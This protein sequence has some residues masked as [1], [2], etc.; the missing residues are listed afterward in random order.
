MSQTRILQQCCSGSDDP[1]NA[2]TAATT[3]S[4]HAAR[5]SK[6]VGHKTNLWICFSIAPYVLDR[7][8]LVPASVNNPLA[9]QG[10]SRLDSEH[11]IR[12]SGCH[13]DKDH[14]LNP[15]YD[16]ALRPEETVLMVYIYTQ[17][18]TEEMKR[19]IMLHDHHAFEIRSTVH[20]FRENHYAT[21]SRNKTRALARGS[22]I[23]ERPENMKHTVDPSAYTSQV[24]FHRPRNHTRHF[25]GMPA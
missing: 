8:A 20:T 21:R 11:I 9:G 3:L 19:E 14:S 17:A 24:F 25:V 6:S 23:L 13:S 18:T 15:T 12:V 7:N 4:T 1:T 5:L 16:N 2:Y 10:S 22:C